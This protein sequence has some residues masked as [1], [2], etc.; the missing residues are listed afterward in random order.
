MKRRTFVGSIIAGIGA[1][2]TPKPENLDKHFKVDTINREPSEKA[3]KE[4]T[5]IFENCS[6]RISMYS[7]FDVS[8]SGSYIFKR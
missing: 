2:V 6:G 4:L 7:S 8:P 3:I 5:T 1:I